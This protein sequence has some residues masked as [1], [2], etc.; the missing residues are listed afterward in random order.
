MKNEASNLI[1]IVCP[2]LESY[3]KAPEDQSHAELSDCPKCSNKMWMSA[4]KRELI[5][6]ADSNEEI[7]LACYSC[8]T[9][10]VNEDPEFWK[11]SKMLKI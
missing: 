3:P 7:L 5:K 1:V 9:E 2:P 8:F 4:K 11:G 10:I 6:F